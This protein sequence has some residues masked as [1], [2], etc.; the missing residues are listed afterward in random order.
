MYQVK[1]KG[2]TKEFSPEEIS[3][4]VLS[5]IKD[6][7]EV[8]LGHKVTEAVVTCPAYFNDSQRQATKDAGTIA[9]L[10]V[11]RIINEPTASA[12][13]YGLDK[14]KESEMNVLIF[15]YGGGTL[16]VSIL[17]LDSGVFEVK[18]SAGDIHCGGE[19]LDNILT[20]FMA[21]EFKRK[22]KKD[23]M[24]NS[25]SVGRLRTACERAKRALSTSTQA[26][27]EIDSLFEGLDF[28][29][30][31]TR[32][33]FEQLCESEFRKCLDPLDRAMLDSK[34]DKSQ[35][36]EIVLIGGS[37]R[38][39]RIQQLIRDRFGG[40]EL[41][42]SINP[43]E[44][45][46]YGAAVQAAVLKG[47]I[48]QKGEDLLLLD[49][50]PL[51]LG[52]E[53]AG[54]MMTVLIKRNTTIPCHKTEMFTTFSDN[55]TGVEI[56]VFEGERAMTQQNNLLGTFH[57]D[58]IA[59]APRGVPKIEVTF[60]IDAN[61]ILQVAAED[62]ATGRNQKITI[63]NDKGRLSQSE[64]DRMVAEAERF[65]AEDERVKENVDAKNKL[66]SYVFSLRNTLSEGKM[67]IPESDKNALEGKLKDAIEWLESIHSNTAIT[68]EEYE[69]KQKELEDFANPI[70]MKAYQQQQQPQGQQ[71]GAPKDQSS[72]PFFNQAQMGGAGAGLGRSGFSSSQNAPPPSS[73][74]SGPKIE[75]VD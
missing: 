25:R 1:Y 23:M 66:E 33:K 19:D 21:D 4:M 63:T 6:L 16:D 17:C 52:L 37:T 71:A 3:S 74:S 72:N 34:L 51:S 50:T 46:A 70:M 11:L 54:G 73:S 14:K 27:I 69:R 38:V 18:A 67:A 48:G 2:E 10:N 47:T 9:G 35:I 26:T 62:K 75:E 61:G 58:G 49:V 20:H 32:A 36:N 40:K 29:S 41:C 44:A 57:L 42:K 53:T 55:Q 45:V 68:K 64:V 24:S 13:A 12:I 39:P 60:D 7:S 15:D 31:N 56:K 28:N 59:P 43:E 5:K 65:K 30:V 22:Y 8:Y